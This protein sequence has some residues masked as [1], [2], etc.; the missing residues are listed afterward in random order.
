MEARSQSFFFF[1]H[2]S[3]GLPA[4]YNSVLDE[5]VGR[6]DVVVFVHDDVTIG[7]VFVREK[8]A[9]AFERLGYGI[10]GLVGTS[11]F[12]ITPNVNAISWLQPPLESCSGA[13]EHQR[14]SMAVMGA[15]GP[16]PKRCVV[17]DGLFLAVDLK[18]TGL[19]RFDNQ[20]A[21]HF[22]D[23]DFCLGAHQAGLMLGTVNVYVTHKSGGGYGSKAFQEAQTKF[24]AKWEAGHY[25]IGADRVAQAEPRRNMCYCGFGH[26]YGV[27]RTRL[28]ARGLL[29]LVGHTAKN[30]YLKLKRYAAGAVAAIWVKRDHP[31]NAPAMK[32]EAEE[33]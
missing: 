6:D 21:F 9:D 4:C 23:L 24:C 2:N 19:L 27:E 31:R 16:T 32:Q 5:N 14:P 1:E 15:Y 18:K 28:W 8:L 30:L 22:Y 29:L 25:R 17:L 10:A 11:D 33:D 26:H 13:V 12:K 3:K 7:D 20:F